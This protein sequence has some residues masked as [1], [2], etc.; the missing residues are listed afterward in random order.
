MG[1]RD[2][3]KTDHDDN[4]IRL[5]NT[6]GDILVDRI[7]AGKAQGDVFLDADQGKVE[8]HASGDT[9]VDITSDNAQ[10]NAHASIGGEQD[11]ETELNTLEAHAG[12]TGDIDINEEDAITLTDV[13]T[14][15]GSITLDAGGSI[16]AL[17][18]ES[19]TDHDDNDIRLHNTSGDILVEL[20]LIHI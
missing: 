1:I 7:D 11:L 15:D 12:T 17:N 19:K 4:D 9:G 13:D 18:V 8:E 20:S 5:H 10:I 3:S 2:R 16:T 14:N 6:S